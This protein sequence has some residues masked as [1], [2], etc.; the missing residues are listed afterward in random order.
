[1]NLVILLHIFVSSLI[2]WVMPGFLRGA[3]GVDSLNTALNQINPENRA[4]HLPCFFNFMEDVHSIA[5]RGLNSVKLQ[6]LVTAI[7][8]SCAEC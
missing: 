7:K 1:M 3:G 8:R 6:Y 2:Q 5:Q 4:V